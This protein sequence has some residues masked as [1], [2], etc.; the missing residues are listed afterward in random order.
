M[1]DLEELALV[2]IGF[3]YAIDNTTCDVVASESDQ[4]LV[5]AL[6]FAV[7]SIY[8]LCEKKLDTYGTRIKLDADMVTNM[9]GQI[10]GCKLGTLG[11]EECVLYENG[12]L[13]S[14]YLVVRFRLSKKMLLKNA[15]DRLQRLC[16][17]AFDDLQTRL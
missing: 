7:R 10:E 8:E 13:E 4:N 12:R 11:G 1:L 14:L 9:A 6:H 2:S 16:K 5:A 3:G 15:M 17:D